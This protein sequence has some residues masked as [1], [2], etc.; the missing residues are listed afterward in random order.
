M[1]EAQ[2][3]IRL[4]SSFELSSSLSRGTAGSTWFERQVVMHRF[5]HS[6]IQFLLSTLL[7]SRTYFS[8][9]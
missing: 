7:W 4:P 1:R 6:M 8:F 2:Q 3:L 5:I 9:V